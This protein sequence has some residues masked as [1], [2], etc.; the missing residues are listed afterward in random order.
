MPVTY[1]EQSAGPSTRA[2]G[3]V[4]PAESRPTTAAT[5]SSQMTRAALVALAKERGLSTSGT[6]RELISRLGGVE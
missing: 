3:G 1:S 4:A 6:K 2:A 5:S